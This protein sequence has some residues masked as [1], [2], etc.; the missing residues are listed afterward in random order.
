MATDSSLTT[1]A[2]AVYDVA[3]DAVSKVNPAVGAVLKTGAIA[4]NI[5]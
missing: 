2:N 5:I 4:G 3:A 1:G